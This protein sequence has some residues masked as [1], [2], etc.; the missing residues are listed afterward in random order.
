MLVEQLNACISGKA[1]FLGAQHEICVHDAEM[2][3]HLTMHA[4]IPI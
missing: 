2:R 1:S 3:A 4:Y